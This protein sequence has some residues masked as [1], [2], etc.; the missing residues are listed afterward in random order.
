MSTPDAGDVDS[1]TQQP[2]DKAPPEKQKRAR[3]E[4][5]AL[6]REPGKSLLPFSRVQKIIKADK[7]IPIVAKDATYLISLATEEFIKRLTESSKMVA[8]RE[9]RATV[10]HRDIATVVRRVDEFLF[11]EEIIPWISADP[12]AKRKLREA[13]VGGLKGQPTMDAFV[14]N[15]NEKSA[16]EGSNVRDD[17]DIIMNEDGTMGGSSRS[18]LLLLLNHPDPELIF[19]SYTKDSSGSRLTATKQ[20]SLYERTTRPAEFFTDIVVHPSGR[21]AVASSYI[22]K[23]RII[24]L[25]AGNYDEDFDVVLPELNLLALT[26]LPL[27]EGNYALG[28]LHVDYQER[29][30]LLARDIVLEDLELSTLPSIVLTPTTISQKVIPYYD[31]ACLRLVPVLP[32]SVEDQEDAHLGGVLVIGGRKILMYDLASKRAQEKQ[33]S[34]RRRLESKKKSS[35]AAEA[36]EA[37]EKEMEKEGRIRKV[38]GSVDWPWSEITACVFSMSVQFRKNSPP[39]SVCDVGPEVPRFVIGD[40]YG[41]LALL[42]LENVKEN[43]MI[44]LPLG[45]ASPASSL[46]YLTSQVIF[47]GSHLGDSQLLQLS[48]TPVSS[49]LSPTL[50]IPHEVKTVSNLGSPSGNKGKSRAMDVDEEEDD[51]KD[52]TKGV[53]VKTNGSFITVLESFKNISPIVDALLVDTY[54]S[55]DQQIVTCSGGGNSGS[56]NIVRNGADFQESASVPG[57]SDVVKLWS[58]RNELEDTHDS[59]ILVSTLTSTHLF[60]MGDAGGATL[61]HVKDTGLVQD[62]GLITELPTLAFANVARRVVDN[63]RKPSYCNSSFVV[64][65]TKKGARLSEYDIVSRTYEK[66]HEWCPDPGT[67]VVAADVNASQI[68]LALK[69]GRLVALVIEEKGLKLN[70]DNAAGRRGS[71][72]EICAI[73]CLPLDPEKKFASHIVVSYWETKTIEVFS[74]DARGLVSNAITPSLP[75][76]ARSVMLY[77]FTS[78]GDSPRQYLFAGLVNGSVAYFTWK[79]K[80]INDRKILSLG[81]TPVSLSA[82]QINGQRT[83]FAAGGRATIFSWEKKRL[84]NSPIMLRDVVAANVLNTTLF[85]SSLILATPTTLFIGRVGDLNKIHIRSFSLGLD[86]PMKISYAPQLK[87][88]GVAVVRTEPKRVGDVQWPQSSFRLLDD[89]T[90]DNMANYNCEPNERL[91]ALATHTLEINGMSTTAFCVGVHKDALE[92]EPNEGRLLILSAKPPAEQTKTPQLQLSL[93]A[94]TEVKGCTY[95][96]SII[97]DMIV[98]AVNSSVM[99]F[100]LNSSGD[101]NTLDLVSEWNHNYLVASLATYGNRIVVGDQVSSVSL[102]E[103]VDGKIQNLARDYGPRWPVA[104]EAVDKNSIIAS[105]FDSNLLTLK[106]TRT[107]GR[108]SLE[109][110]GNYYVADFVTKFIRGSLTS[111]SSK[112]MDIEASHVFFTSSGRIGVILDVTEPTLSLHLTSLQRNLAGVVPSIGGDSHARFRAPKSRKGRSDADPSAFGFIDGDFIEQFLAYMGSPDETERILA[113]NSDP[114]RLTMP[115]EEIQAVLENLQSFH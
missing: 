68:F 1:E 57:L 92:V 34:K 114:E 84:H 89:T 97:N 30:H 37:R 5:V 22:G 82:C 44:L 15:Q 42:S 32:Q 107:L 109:C 20:L 64:Q 115:V 12:P 85:R 105:N 65:V 99:L 81:N 29:I 31:D 93:L 38:Q 23:L 18:N 69:G 58:I 111:S 79:D 43:G 41:R 74:I 51:S 100:K 40:N 55:G 49:L 59:H 25:K 87:A 83:V 113:G 45:E 50:P 35:D 63:N 80:Q 98:A 6:I 72:P 73:S 76:V 10:Q 2:M 19:L 52:I 95:A 33:G 3:K 67:E 86:N 103:V 94:A 17:D 26:F 102:L 21:V 11:L 71:L 28:I 54:G 46:T 13:A 96:I 24:K 60:R 75:A 70:I 77:N 9:K 91:T 7:E 53:V 48:P 16:A 39:F 78:Q 110:D 14:V 104:V 4:P 112:N 8:E 47:L 88:F 66:V 61:S 90:F 27:D 36:K 106:L 101:I 108:S 56:L 62:S